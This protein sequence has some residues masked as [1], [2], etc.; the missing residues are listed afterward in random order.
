MGSITVPQPAHGS[1]FCNSGVGYS[2]I[3][4]ALNALL[5]VASSI[6]TIKQIALGPIGQ[7]APPQAFRQLCTQR[8]HL[9]FLA[10]GLS[11]KQQ[12]FIGLYATELQLRQFA[13]AQSASADMA[14]HFAALSVRQGFEDALHL[15]D[16]FGVIGEL[17]P[18]TGVLF[19]AFDI[20]L[21]AGMGRSCF[22]CTQCKYS[23]KGSRRKTDMWIPPLWWLSA[24]SEAESSRNLSSSQPCLFAT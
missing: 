10:L 4:Q 7:I 24:C 3:E 2:L 17:H 1:R 11:Y 12:A 21:H 22:K 5:A 20:G 18:D 13:P 9:V 15:R 16:E 19:G 14:E 23:N 8:Q 6:L